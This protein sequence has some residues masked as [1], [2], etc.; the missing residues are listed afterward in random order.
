MNLFSRALSLS[1]VMTACALWAQSPEPAAEVASIYTLMMVDRLAET[2]AYRVVFST[3]IPQTTPFKRAGMDGDQPW[4]IDGEW[5]NSGYLKLKFEYGRPEA[6]LR[7]FSVRIA[8]PPNTLKCL[9]PS[10]KDGGSKAT[11]LFFLRR[12]AQGAPLPTSQELTEA[13]EASSWM[14]A[15]TLSGESGE[16]LGGV[17]LQGRII[18]S[19]PNGASASPDGT[20]KPKTP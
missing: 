20:D 19:P 7:A 8:L 18:S 11:S 12:S 6:N 3:E 15:K 16:Y 2:G 14:A 4:K 5:W 9:S 10:A 1:A 13:I 17:P